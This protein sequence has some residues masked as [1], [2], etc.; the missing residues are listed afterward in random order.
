MGTLKTRCVIIG[1]GDCSVSFLKENIDVETDFI[2]CADSGYDYAVSA[3]IT[4]DLLIGDFDSISAVPNGLNMITLPVEK[5][6]T[7]CVAAFNEGVKFGYKSFVLFGGTGGRFEHTL[8]NISL[9]ANASRQNISFEIL[10]EKHIFR[11]ITDSSIIIERKENQQISVFAYG[12]RAFGVTESGFHY[13][14]WDFTLDPFDGALG[15]S[16]DIVEEVGEISVKSGTLVIV[17]TKM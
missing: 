7:D 12:G 16:N 6:I 9:M 13:P 2:I 8:A 3:N 15:T 14:L 17:K 1:G 5:D 10:D 4:P 11:S